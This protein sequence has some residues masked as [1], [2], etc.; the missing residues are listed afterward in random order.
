[1]LGLSLVEL[2]VAM[3]V[4]LLIAAGASHVFINT[5]SNFRFQANMSRMSDSARFGLEFLRRTIRMAAYRGDGLAEWAEGPLT[6]AAFGVTALQGADND[7]D[8]TNSIKDGTDVLTI[9]YEGS[10]DGF[11]KDCQG[12]V[13][14][15][16]VQAT[17][18]Y[19]I[20]TTNVLQCSIDGGTTF[21]PL[22]DGVENMQV[23][24]GVDSDAD[25]SANRYVTLGSV[26]STDN[27]VSVRVA[28]LLVSA[29]DSLA[30]T[31]DKRTY[32]VLDETV[33]DALTPANDR[34]LRRLVST[35]VRLR[36]RI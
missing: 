35:T 1:M 36:N 8:P 11:I 18:S 21:Q 30:S 34:R 4:G 28:L 29:D 3:I 2:M 17:S 7:V 6:Q 19:A 5:R 16:G 24:H 27:V 12:G 14:P 15:A 13:V 25:G 33:Y 31:I 9:A 20:S 22:V 23:L 10:A 26:G 32:Q